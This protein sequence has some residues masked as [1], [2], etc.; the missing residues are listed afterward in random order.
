MRSCAWAPEGPP[1]VQSITHLHCQASWLLPS[2][3]SKGPAFSFPFLSLLWK[4]VKVLNILVLTVWRL[5][6][7][8]FPVSCCH[9]PLLNLSTLQDPS[10]WSLKAW[11]PS[12]L[13]PIFC[14]TAARMIQPAWPGLVSQTYETT[15]ELPSEPVFFKAPTPRD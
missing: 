2:S 7:F 9:P 1:P 10:A 6:L 13:W 8:F 4:R 12:F 5:S 11:L 15:L 3:N 14:L